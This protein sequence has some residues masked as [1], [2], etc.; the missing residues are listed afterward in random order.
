MTG[1]MEAPNRPDLTG[2]TAR[3]RELCLR[4]AAHNRYLAPAKR[5]SHAGFTI[6]PTDGDPFPIAATG[7]V[8]WA[9]IQLVTAGRMG[10]TPILHPAPRWS[11]YIHDL[12]KLG[13]EIETLTEKHGGDYPGHHG[14]Y[15]LQCRVTREGGVT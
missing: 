3:G 13:V 4:D 10:C 1:A 11:A 12:R 14:R 7:R 6:H 15:V 8:R 2:K 5:Q 9:L